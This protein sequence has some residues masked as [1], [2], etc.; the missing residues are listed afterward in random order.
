MKRTGGKKGGFGKPGSKGGGGNIIPIYVDG[1][2]QTAY[3]S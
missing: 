3:S 1:F 2:V